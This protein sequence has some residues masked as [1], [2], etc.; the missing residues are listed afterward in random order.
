VAGLE[1]LVS[2][3]LACGFREEA[4]EAAGEI[5]STA[6][7]IGTRPLQ[8]AALLAEAR[9]A[10]A[11]GDHQ[12]ARASFEDAAASFEATGSPY[13]AGQSSL[14]A[15]EALRAAGK[16]EAAERAERRGRTMLARL[17]IVDNARSSGGGTLSDREREVL[18]LLA[19]GRSNNEI[20]AALVLSTRTVERHVANIYRK[21]RL[22]GRSA[23]A[24]AASW[25]HAHGI[26]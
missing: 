12:R 14:G 7:A 9:V 6:A 8:A 2:A 3:A 25:S 15:A 21:L 13:E 17:G 19:Q 11:D 1:L 22:T 16:A 23:R 24:A 4:T 5:R 18:V 20:A 10:A 26:G